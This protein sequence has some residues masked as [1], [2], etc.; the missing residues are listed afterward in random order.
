MFECA[1]GTVLSFDQLI[2][3]GILI[4]GSSGAD[5]IGGT[6]YIDRMT[7]EGGHDVLFGEEGVDQISGGDGGDILMGGEGN[8]ILMGDA[9]NDTLDGEAGDDVLAGG[10]GDD[11]LYGGT[12]SDQYR[13]NLGDGLDTIIEIDPASA[14]DT[15]VFGSGIVA[16]DARLSVLDGG[17]VVRVGAGPEGVRL[18]TAISSG[19]GSMSWARHLTMR[20]SEPIWV[21]DSLAALGMIRCRVAPATTRTTLMPAMDRTSSMM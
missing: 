18:G 6:P 8:D 9:G 14:V 2:A 15:V 21:I 19:E 13:Y 20:S 17:L 11:T 3:R 7:G 4:S 10:S 5:S 1:D 12:G 16:D